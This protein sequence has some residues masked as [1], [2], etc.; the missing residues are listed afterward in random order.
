ML[1]LSGL[2]KHYPIQSRLPFFAPKA[3]IKA[4]DGVSLAID[5]G[6]T[7]GLVGE[8]GCGKT[9]IAKMVLLLEKPTQGVVRF[10]GFDTA[11]MRRA[12]LQDYRRSVQAVFQDPWSSLSPRMRASSIITEPLVTSTQLTASERRERVAEL[13]S[14]VG[15]HASM[16]NHFPHEF[17]GG[18][19]QRI[20]IAR[21]LG[22]EPKLVVLDEPVSSLDVSI[23]AQIMNLLKSLQAVRGLSYLLIAHDLAT[24]RYLSDRVAVMYLGQIVE[25]A[26]SR[27]LFQEPLHP[28]SQALLAASLPVGVDRR[29]RKSTLP[30]EVP[31]PANPPPG[32]RFNTRC[33]KAFERCPVEVPLL[34]E[35]S[36][37]HKVACHLYEV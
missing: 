5:Q 7:L 6:E 10:E 19:R 20:A 12:A 18:Q 4:V 24:V 28:Y 23:R 22:P 2:K 37:G 33:P 15:L 31:S 16:A 8:S 9:T 36:P 14:S 35:L 29:Q 32:C 30:E 3:W 26:S 11:T 1:E 21:A 27:E 17:S 25:E 13:L 34:R